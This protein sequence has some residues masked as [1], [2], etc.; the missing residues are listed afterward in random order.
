MS[1]LPHAPHAVRRKA[2]AAHYTPSNVA[3]FQPEMHDYTLEVVEVRPIQFIVMQLSDP[4]IL[5]QILEQTGGK[6]AVDVLHLFREM[7]VDIICEASFNFKVGALKA[8]TKDGKQHCLVRA[9]DDFPKAGV[10][11]RLPM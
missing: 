9:I 4:H 7:L 1:I 2:F 11:V 3:L 5:P 10:L 8:R 6:E